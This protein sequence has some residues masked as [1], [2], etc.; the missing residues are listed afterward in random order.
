MIR[1]IV[2]FFLIVQVRLIALWKRYMKKGQ[3]NLY[4]TGTVEIGYS[5]FGPTIGINGTLRAWNKDVFVRS[6]DLMVVREKD[7]SQP[8][9]LLL[10]K[11]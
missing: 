8:N 2:S 6:I 5:T 9:R 1:T 11:I 4:E 3:I 10:S 7:K